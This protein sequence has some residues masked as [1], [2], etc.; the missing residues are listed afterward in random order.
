M[1][2]KKKKKPTK[3]KPIDLKLTLENF[4]PLRKAEVDLKPMTIFIGP[5]NSGKS[6]VAMMFY[7]LFHSLG[8]ITTFGLL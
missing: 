6:Y 3:P 1:S 7:S 2:P 8:F 4:G 5:N